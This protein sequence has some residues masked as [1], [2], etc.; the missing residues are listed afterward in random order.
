MSIIDLTGH[1]IG[2]LVV[3]QR[4]P[5]IGKQPAWK[6]Q[7]A[8]GGEKIVAGMYLR[9]ARVH[10]CGCGSAERRRAG[11]VRHGL[12]GAPEWATWKSMRERCVR[13]KAPAWEH[14]GGRGIT[15]CERWLESFE[16]FYADMGPR[17]DGMT[18]DRIDNNGNYDP[19]N[20]RWATMEEQQNNRRSN[21]LVT[22]DGETKT[23]KQWATHFGVPY[24]VVKDRRSK[25]VEGAALFA[26]LERRAYNTKYEHAGKALTITGWAKELG[27]P[28]I[29]VWQRIH[30]FG[31]HPD[32]S[33]KP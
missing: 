20:C 9:T 28:Y 29:T 33:K 21:V 8:C 32:G 23:L 16:N 24:P 13:P 26:P 5:N 3:V 10:D 30:L 1:V 22:L 7:C 19:G 11:R 6:C 12:T 15:V 14:Y 31:M 18:L 27:A 2:K 25:G 4:A 17:P